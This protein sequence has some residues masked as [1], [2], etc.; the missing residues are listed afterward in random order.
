VAGGWLQCGRGG[1]NGWNIK[2]YGLPVDFSVRSTEA[3]IDSA[4]LLAALGDSVGEHP[5]S[6]WWDTAAVA[7]DPDQRQ[8]RCANG[9]VVSGEEIVLAAGAGIPALIPDRGRPWGIP[10]ILAGRGV[11]LLLNAPRVEV[12]H[13]VRTPN[14]AFAC[15]VHVVPRADGTL[16]LGGTNRLT[17]GPDPDLRA[18][19]DE[20]ATLTGDAITTLDHRVGAAETLATRVGLRPYCPDHQP[21]LGRTGNP[22]LL[23]ATATYRCG[24][25]LAPRL[26]AL[27]ADEID[28][29]GSLADHPY[30]ATRPMPEPG[31]DTVLA[32]GA[33][34]GAVEHLLRDGGRLAPAARDELTAWMAVALRAVLAD[35]DHPSLAAQRRLWACAPVVEAVPSLLA[36]ATRTTP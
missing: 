5:L 15:G 7:V 28:M 33:A 25:L 9:T 21:L 34:T 27:L 3:R 23:V 30:R 12:P 16:Y 32:D 24:V 4:I 2:A 6:C 29:P 17:T 26:A 20:L 19:T 10:P 31:I 13:V 14:A 18:T 35:R 36:L 11:S 1:E 8:V 22:H